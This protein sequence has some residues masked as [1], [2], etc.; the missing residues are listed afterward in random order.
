MASKVVCSL[1][2]WVS[3]IWQA[4]KSNKDD[5]NII[6]QS[7]LQLLI[8]KRNKCVWLGFA[9]YN[10]QCSLINQSK[11]ICTQKKKSKAN[12][13]MP[14]DIFL[15]VVEHPNSVTNTGKSGMYQLEQTV[16]WCYMQYKLYLFIKDCKE[17]QQG[18]VLLG[19]IFKCFDFWKRY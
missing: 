17:W 1:A 4:N 19:R 15:S 11:Q 14:D 8:V 18:L 6:I 3:M 2:S 10:I 16:M 7:G 12:P 13:S 5:M 9:F